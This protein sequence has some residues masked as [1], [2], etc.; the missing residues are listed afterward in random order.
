MAECP[1]VDGVEKA[2]REAVIAA[3]GGILVAVLGVLSWSTYGFLAC[4]V[5]ALAFGV[6]ARRY[7]P[8]EANAD[9]AAGG[10][11]LAVLALRLSGVL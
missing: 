10:L 4:G 9:F 8:M 1:L 3:W 6:Y 7:A 2:H 11:L 5:G